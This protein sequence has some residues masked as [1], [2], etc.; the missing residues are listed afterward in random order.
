MHSPMLHLEEVYRILRYLKNL[1]QG[2]LY[3]RQKDLR[4]K[5]FINVDWA[6]SLDDNK[7]TSG[8]YTFVE[9]NPV[10]WRSKKQPVVAQS[11]VEDKFKT[12]AHEIYDILWIYGLLEEWRFNSQGTMWL[13]CNNKATISIVHNP[14]QH[15]RAKHITVDR[16]FIKEKL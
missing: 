6:G 1:S 12:M 13:Y 3:G 10:T 9:G 8:Y 11:S 7:S 4:V 15:D 16:H 14:I 5:A 2:P